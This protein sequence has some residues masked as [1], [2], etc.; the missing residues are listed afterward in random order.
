M[1]CAVP[2]CDCVDIVFVNED[3]FKSGKTGGIRYK[4]EGNVLI[5]LSGQRGNDREQ[6]TTM[7]PSAIFSS[8]D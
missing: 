4:R 1:T 3:N 8:D 7:R 6:P 5:V 2:A